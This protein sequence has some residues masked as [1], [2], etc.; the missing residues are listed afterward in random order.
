[1]HWQ[2]APDPGDRAPAVTIIGWHGMTLGCRRWGPA[3][4]RSCS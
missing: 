3:G 4:P 2:P 1:M